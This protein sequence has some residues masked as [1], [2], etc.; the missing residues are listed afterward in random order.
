MN[1]NRFFLALLL[2]FT[3]NCG[4]T[5]HPGQIGLFWKPFGVTDVGLS[6]DPVLNGFYW[7]LPWNDIYTYSTQW[8]SH[9]EKVDV[10][11][12]DDL[13]IDVQAVIILRPIREEIYQLHIEVGPEY[14]RSIVQPEFRASIRNVVSHHQMIQISKNSAVL[15]KD[16]KTAVVERTKGKHIEVFDVILDDIEYSPNMLHAIEAKLTKQQ[17]LEQQKYELEIAEKNIEIAKKKARAD[18]EAQLIRADAQAK[19]Q[20]IINDKLTTKYLQYKSFESPNSKLI[21]V[22]Q[23]KDNLPIVVNPKD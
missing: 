17:E 8:D 12:N 2:V 9:K 7:L 14:Y 15:A 13:K 18:A 16:I 21:F 23:G 19:S 11:T 4:S 1:K 20:A 6:K 3:L 10:L 5:V 22:P